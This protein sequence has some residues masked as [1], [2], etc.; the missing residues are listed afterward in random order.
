M[1]KIK[2]GETKKLKEAIEKRYRVVDYKMPRT[3]LHII[4]DEKTIE[5]HADSLD[6]EYIIVD[7]LNEIG[8]KSQSPFGHP[9]RVRSG[10]PGEKSHKPAQ[11]VKD[12]SFEPKTGRIAERYV[13]DGW[14]DEEKNTIDVRT[15]FGTYSK[16]K[17]SRNLVRRINDADMGDFVCGKRLN[18]KKICVKI[19]T[20][21]Y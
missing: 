1:I 15:G 10:I 6:F 17:I 8:F 21:Y 13:L 3:H 9:L 12:Y 20:R 4:S 19:G 2:K 7:D 14:A 16:I 18:G 5:P 11:M